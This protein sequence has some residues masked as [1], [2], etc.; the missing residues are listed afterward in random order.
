MH[1]ASKDIHFLSFYCILTTVNSPTSVWII[2]QLLATSHHSVHVF[3]HCVEIHKRY[4]RLLIIQE[5]LEKCVESFI[6]RNAL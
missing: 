1:G 5:D 2:L 4:R 3:A 6:L